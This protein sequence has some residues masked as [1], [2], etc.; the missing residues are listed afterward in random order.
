MTI[1]IAFAALAAAQSAAPLAPAPTA[2]AVIVPT[3]PQ[4]VILS[5]PAE[6]V[7]RAG[8]E[9]PL[10]M[11]ES[12][13]TNG[14]NIRVGQRIR[15]QVA[16][17]V[18]LDARRTQCGNEV[19]ADLVRFGAIAPFIPT[20][21]KKA[22]SRGASCVYGHMGNA[23][24]PPPEGPE[25]LAQGL[26]RAFPVPQSGAFDHLLRAISDAEKNTRL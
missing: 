12:I 19:L 20:D 17:D 1:S 22:H 4:A 5:A 16:S 6:S 14:K 11:A 25:H 3:A 23:R 18:R 8:T 21:T 7:L 24:Q 15:L 13:T 10:I 26:K 9:V 2:P